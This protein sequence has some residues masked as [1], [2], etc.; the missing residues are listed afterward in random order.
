MRFK[1]V[2]LLAAAAVLAACGTGDAAGAHKSRF[3]ARS[4]HVTNPWFPLK[5]GTV[6]RYKGEEDGTP[7]RDVVRVTHH[8]KLIDGVRCR[9][10]HDRVIKHGRVVE[11]TRDFYAQDR[12][13]TVWYTGENTK[14]LDRHGHVTSREG[15]WQSG[16]HGARRGIMMPRHPHVGFS[17]RQEYRKG[18]AEDHFKVIRRHGRRLVTKEWSPLEKGV[19]DHKFYVRGIGNVKEKTVKGGDEVL[20]LVSISH[21]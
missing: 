10:V 2:P 19:V 11:D 3:G 14:E 12:H 16:K 21:G 8:V 7:Q 4:A 1:L 15:S 18:T 5:P 9:V 17:A 6:Y 13:G 20:H